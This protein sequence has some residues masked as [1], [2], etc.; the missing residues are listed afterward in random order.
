MAPVPAKATRR[1]QTNDFA[2]EVR[3]TEKVRI[4]GNVFTVLVFAG[5]FAAAVLSPQAMAPLVMLYALGIAVLNWRNFKLAPKSFLPIAAGVSLLAWALASALWSLDP[6]LSLE[7]SL[8]LFLM[9]ALA[10]LVAIVLPNVRVGKRGALIIAGA[11]FCAS[12]LIILDTVLG[13]SIGPHLAKG[14]D[15]YDRTGPL[16]VLLLLPTFT[17]IDGRFG[18]KVSISLVFLSVAAVLL[19]SNKASVLALILGLGA[20]IVYM[21]LRRFGPQLAVAAILVF[22]VVQ[23][24]GVAAF[25]SQIGQWSLS[26]NAESGIRHRAY[27]WAFSAE[28][29]LERPVFGWGIGTSRAV[30]GGDT[31]ATF[32]RPDGTIAGQGEAIPLH[33]HNAFLQV[34]LEMGLVG[35]G[36]VALTLSVAAYRFAR[37]LQPA[38]L[39]GPG[40]AFIVAALTISSISFGAWQ[41]WWVSAQLLVGALLTGLARTHTRAVGKAESVR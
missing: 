41:G 11:I 27:I 29:A 35:M 1:F 26:S 4:Y 9:I 19:L 10:A 23:P 34:F 32:L 36:L 21:A 40:I 3:V 22:T 24:L 14:G 37:L 5:S 25:H 16:F 20:W 7:R 13:L 33:P 2:A 6:G 17:I 30:P 18:R 15:P 8:R 12:G 31:K 39:L 28:K 38:G